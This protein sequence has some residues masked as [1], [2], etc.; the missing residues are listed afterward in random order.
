MTLFE[1]LRRLAG[2]SLEDV[3]K[4]TCLSV[5][6]LSLIESGK[7]KITPK[8][9]KKYLKMLVESALLQEQIIITKNHLVYT[10]KIK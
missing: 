9:K 5:S 7:R 6:M 8:Y 4:K 10:T 2:Y 3:G 1:L